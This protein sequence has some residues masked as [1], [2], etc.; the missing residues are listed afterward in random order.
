MASGKSATWI[1]FGSI[2][3]RNLSTVVDGRNPRIRNHQIFQA[4][5]HYQSTTSTTSL[6]ACRVP[7][8]HFTSSNVTRQEESGKPASKIDAIK[9]AIV[10]GVKGTQKK[11]PPAKRAP[12]NSLRKVAFE[13]QRNRQNALIRGSGRT[14]YVDPEA[15]TKEVTAYC[16][17]E[18]YSLPTARWELERE[19]YVTDPYGVGLGGQVIH[20]QTPNY[21]IRDEETGEDKPQGTGDVFVFPSGCAVF[22]NVPDNLARTFVKRFLP[23]AAGQTRG[24]VQYEMENMEYIEDPTKDSSQIIGD[25]I[26]LGTKPMEYHS[27]SDAEAG[28]TS[29]SAPR[30]IFED[31]SPEIDT[32]LAKIAFSSGLARSTKLADLEET[33]NTYFANTQSIPKT[34]AEGKKLSINRSQI[35]QRT[36][37]LLQIRAQLNLYSELTDALPDLFWDS[38]HELGLEGYYEKVGKALDVSVRIKILNERMD[39]ASEIAAV[40]R[41]RLSEKH[42]TMLEWM[43]IG[44]IC[45][46]VGFGIVHLWR[47]NEM[48]TEKEDEKRTRELLEVWLER[49]LR[50]SAA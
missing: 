24:K 28:N 47:E 22:W 46:E 40:L 4:P 38:P 36:G 27:S 17:A 21:V 45:I 39:H 37:E 25:T 44:L 29:S 48:L 34:L 12:S 9:N 14:R 1:A 32:T 35:L 18:K 30:E 23:S 10:G 49:E 26:I 2:F 15:D 3:K 19:G 20:V 50:K 16:A 5:P 41:E 7:R 31:R 11:S 42:S 6:R 8:N 33:L 43:I 13:A